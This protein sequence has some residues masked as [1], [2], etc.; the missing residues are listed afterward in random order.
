[1]RVR[2]HVAIAFVWFGSAPILAAPQLPAQNKIGPTAHSRSTIKIVSEPEG[3]VSAQSGEQGTSAQSLNGDISGSIRGTVLDEQG[4]GIPGARIILN[5]VITLE[6]Y[7]L[8]SAGNGEFTFSEIPPG[9]YS[10]I[11]DAEGFAPYT[12][13]K[14]TLTAQQTYEV[15]NVQLSI[16]TQKAEVTVRP[17][18]VIA[19]MQIKA[20]EK[21]RLLGFIPQYHTSYVWDAAP[22]NAKQKFSLTTREF[23]DPVSLIGAGATAG[24]QQANNSFSGYGQGALGY[25]TRFAAALGNDLVSSYLSQAVFPSIFHQDPRY[26][27][28]GSGSTRSRLW[29]ALSWAVIARSDRGHL[30]PNYSFL[31]GDLTAGAVSNLYY[32]PANRGAG[33]VL[34]NFA[35]GVASQAGKDVLREFLFK[36][37]TKNVPGDGKP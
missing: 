34:T 32:P 31:L 24:V 33:V 4:T 27:Y 7:N 28:Q 23:L 1:M 21:Q 30:M 37:L 12:S 35:I 17:P 15:P 3:Q 25:G 8:T 2:R 6:Q 36:R 9:T 20:E 29:H 16:A 18:E 14:I 10:L 19:R 13:S 26:F 5:N 11:V 22:L